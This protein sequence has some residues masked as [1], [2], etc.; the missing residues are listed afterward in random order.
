[1]EHDAVVD[2]AAHLERLRAELVGRGWVAEVGAVDKQPALHVRNPAEASMHDQVIC[3]GEIFA[4]VWG[5][6]IGQVACLA[7]AAD[8]I[9]FVLQEVAP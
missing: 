9:M 4:W 8:R 2:T 7:E 1:M 5:G 6:P 3:R